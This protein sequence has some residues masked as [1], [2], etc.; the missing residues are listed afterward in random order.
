[1]TLGAGD[2]MV[3]HGAALTFGSGDPERLDSHLKAVYAWLAGKA[4]NT[5][6]A[7]LAAW[8]DFFS[9]TGWVAPERVTAADVAR[10]KIYLQAEGRTDSTVY[11][12]LS[13]L[14][15]YYDYISRPIGASE[16]GLVKWN[17]VRGVGRGDL[18]YTA[19]PKAMEWTAFERMLSSLGTEPIDI[20][21][22][23]ILLFF[24]YTGR[25][26]SEVASLRLRNF[27]FGESPR[28]YEC[29]VKG[30]KSE[31]WELPTVCYDAIVSYLTAWGRTELDPND[32]LF[33]SSLP[34]HSREFE[35][36]T[37][38][39]LGDVLRG[40]A[41]K[42]GYDP[43]GVSL[44]QLRHMA[45][46]DLEAAGVDTRKI[47]EFLGHSSIATTE[48]Y[49]GLLSGVR[50][51]FEGQLRQARSPGREAP[52]VTLPETPTMALARKAASRAKEALA[53]VVTTA[54]NVEL[55]GVDVPAPGEPW[56]IM[57]SYEPA[58]GSRRVMRVF[59]V[60]L[61]GAAT[62]RTVT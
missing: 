44:H 14:S 52:T 12:R 32:G 2:G 30:G 42:A 7:Y 35:P 20:R 16:P 21:D 22:K 9:F 40:A 5:R 18:G 54:E 1:M 19:T 58:A 10:W 60:Q 3:P 8:R 6:R 15:S 38:T 26:R 59:D 27:H 17:P 25:R 13:A 11:A 33:L 36:M 51:S 62:M 31:R 49:L 41:R 56:V 47:Q 48:T 23:A 45:A 39:A 46:H 55:Q 61:D 28:W 24:A 29:K 50:R 4:S 37:G 57:L 53:A 43:N 34:R